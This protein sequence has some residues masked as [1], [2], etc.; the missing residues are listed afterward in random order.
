MPN[1][2]LK[3]VNVEKM[4]KSSGVN[5]HVAAKIM[6]PT[7]ERWQRGFQYTKVFSYAMNIVGKGLSGSECKVIM[8]LL[9]YIRYD[10]GML[11][12][13]K[14]FPL[15]NH[16]IIGLVNMSKRTVSDIMDGLVRKR[17]FARSRVGVCNQYFANPYIFLRGSYINKTLKAMFRNYDLKKV[18]TTEGKGGQ[19][20]PSNPYRC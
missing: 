14:G 11:T 17:I 1:E 3:V 20:Q 12:T 4:A 16:D 8:L 9:G 15:T 5:R 19:K 18:C 6:D 7:L 10:T 2:M 13:L